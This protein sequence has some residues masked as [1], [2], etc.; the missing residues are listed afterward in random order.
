M[1]LYSTGEYTACGNTYSM[2]AWSSS[3]DPLEDL[4][5]TPWQTKQLPLLDWTVSPGDMFTLVIYDVGYLFFNGVYI[6]INGAD[7]SSAEVNINQEG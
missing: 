2:D 6:N 3:I 4:V 1:F 7:M 5:V